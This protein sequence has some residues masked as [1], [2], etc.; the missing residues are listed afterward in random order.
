[1]AK[2]NVKTHKIPIKHYNFASLENDINYDYSNRKL[3][4]K[5]N[6]ED[7]ESINNHNISNEDILNKEKKR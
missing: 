5:L 7:K 2:L 6:K 4:K 1:M 3:V